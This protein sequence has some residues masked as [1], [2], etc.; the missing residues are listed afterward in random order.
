MMKCLRRA[1]KLIKDF[2]VKAVKIGPLTFERKPPTREAVQ[3]RVPSQMPLTEDVIR[4][5][6]PDDLVF[7]EVEVKLSDTWDELMTWLAQQMPNCT[8]LSITEDTEQCSFYHSG[9]PGHI[10]WPISVSGRKKGVPFKQRYDLICDW[11]HPAA[12]ALA[13]L[14][15]GL[16]WDTSLFPVKNSTEEETRIEAATATVRDGVYWVLFAALK[17]S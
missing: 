13:P 7:R 12:L 2:K 10:E 16:P 4:A 1:A 15:V 8:I 17:K 5:T 3:V 9:K 11:L 14:D 6:D